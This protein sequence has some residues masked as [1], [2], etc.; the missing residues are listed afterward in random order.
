MLILIHQPLDLLAG[1]WYKS[2]RAHLTPAL[3]FIDP[4]LLLVAATAMAPLHG[5][6]LPI[7]PTAR[8]AVFTLVRGDGP[9][10]IG[11]F[12]ERTECLRQSF[13]AHGHGV[14]EYDLIVFHVGRLAS[15]EW[16]NA[17]SHLPRLR[18]VDATK[19]GGFDGAREAFVPG[20]A[21]YPV[22]YFHMC[23]FMALLWF[24]ALARYEYA[25]RIDEDVCVR[26]LAAEPF[27]TM[28][29][30]G[31]VYMYGAEVDE[32][33]AETVATMR[34]WLRERYGVGVH[35]PGRMYFTNFFVARVVWW[36]DE[37]VQA[38]LHAVELSKNIYRHRWGDAPIITAALALHA[39]RGTV[40]HLPME[41]AHLSTTDWIA[42]D[43]TRTPLV[44]EAVI[45][46]AALGPAMR[47]LLSEAHHSAINA[48]NATNATDASSADGTSSPVGL[49]VV[50][51]QEMDCT[52]P[53]V[54]EQWQEP[55]PLSEDLSVCVEGD[56]NLF[57]RTWVDL[58]GPVPYLRVGSYPDSLC[59]GPQSW[60]DNLLADGV[61][62]HWLTSI[63]ASVRFDARV[64]PTDCTEAPPRFTAAVPVPAT[65]Y[66]YHSLEPGQIN[67]GGGN[68]TVASAD[69]CRRYCDADSDCVAYETTPDPTQQEL[70]GFNCCLEYCRP[71]PLAAVGA[72]RLF[73][74]AIGASDCECWAR[75]VV[76]PT[77]RLHACCRE[78]A[79][80]HAHA[81]SIAP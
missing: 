20:N 75:G 74:S 38:F 44:S 37:D 35:D 18:W 21:T 24:R 65:S 39:K 40:A 78:E 66:E 17:T 49:L 33:H 80:V 56:A 4:M 54:L 26:R 79:P 12:L 60:G 15:E 7:V 50:Y 61:S 14:P 43:G 1:T 63:Q 6:V 71:P 28:R 77:V 16:L 69:D 10:E 67:W 30:H 25:M 57:Q 53:T 46:R 9:H 76:P 52:G 23:H 62:C 51:F 13:A 41:Y 31:L 19:Y 29:R 27:S 42:L 8:D 70:A 34:P 81:S 72:S 73:A 58:S 47:R 11:S 3:T 48:T 22:G 55:T 64:F 5:A 45:S 59:A 2:Q 68:C 32:S 36:W